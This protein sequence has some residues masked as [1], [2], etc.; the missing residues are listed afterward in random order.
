M[1]PSLFNH[2]LPNQLGH[3][4]RP[5]LSTFEQLRGRK[6]ARSTEV[7][8]KSVLRPDTDLVCGC[9]LLHKSVYLPWAPARILLQFLL[10][11][12]L[13]SC[14]LSPAS[15][16]LHLRA[17][18]SFCSV[19]M[20]CGSMRAATRSRTHDIRQQIGIGIVDENMPLSNHPF[21][22][23]LDFSCILSYADRHT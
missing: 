4:L 8:Y 7:D 6:H 21:M 3:K 5:F 13:S 14:L 16:L 12:F 15:Y 18:T 9:G 2:S 23:M 19:L 22:E 17:M 10:P 1:I 20:D 11:S